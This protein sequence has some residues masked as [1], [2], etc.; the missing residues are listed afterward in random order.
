MKN[1]SIKSYL[2]SPSSLISFIKNRPDHWYLKDNESKYIFV[3]KAAFRFFQ[4]PNNFNEEGRSDKE[5][6]TKICEE[7][8]P[9]FINHDKKVISENRM[10]TSIDIHYY[11]KGNSNTLIPHLSEKTP[12]YD[13]NNNIIGIVGYGK[14]IDAPTLLYYINKLNR[15]T[16]EI[17]APNDIFT[18]REL[19]VIFWAQ[20]RL[21]VKEIARRLNVAVQ[22]VARH[23]K[24]IYRKADIHSMIQLIEYCQHTGLDRYIPADFI[25]KG[26]QL[27][28]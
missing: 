5:I 27:V 11:G 2:S 18:K 3:N 21:C 15:K 12:L 19:E 7:L 6:P 25:R 23:L 22:T 14:R 13:D 26:V 17:D 8:W 20:Q 9:E 4:F 1:A 16:I 24:H 10:I 28:S